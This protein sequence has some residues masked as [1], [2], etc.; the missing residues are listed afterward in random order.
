MHDHVQTGSNSSPRTRGRNGCLNC[1][2]RRKKCDEKKPTCGKCSA[3]GETCEVDDRLI[4]RSIGLGHCHPSQGESRTWGP[5]ENHEVQSPEKTRSP[6]ESADAVQIISID[7][8]QSTEG[9]QCKRRRIHNGKSRNAFNLTPGQPEDDLLNRYSLIDNPSHDIDS[10]TSVTSEVLSTIT[11]HNTKDSEQRYRRHNR[12]PA[13]DVVTQHGQNCASD[14]VSLI[15]SED[16]RGNMYARED[17]SYSNDQRQLSYP[18][19][20]A[21]TSSRVASSHSGMRRSPGSSNEGFSGDPTKPRNLSIP[22]ECRVPPAQRYNSCSSALDDSVSGIMNQSEYN[23]FDYSHATYQDLH[24]TLYKHMV[25]TAQNNVFT[26]QASPAEEVP[27]ESS[28]TNGL[29][30][31]HRT[32]A[33]QSVDISRSVCGEMAADHL[34]L[35]SLK[36]SQHRQLELW[37]NYLDEVAVW[38]DMFDND[39]HFQFSIPLLAKSAD[40][41]QYAILA[42]SSRQLER[43][44][45]DESNTES[46]GLYQEAIKLIIKELYTLD[47]AVIASCVLLCVLEMMSS[48]PRAW[49]RHLDGCAKLL[50]AASVNGV[51]GGIGQ[52]VFWCFARMDVWGG[53]LEDTLTKIP[54]SRWYI[55]GDSMEDLMTHFKAD[56]GY[57]SYA[58]HAV[59]LCASVVNVISA[60]ANEGDSM[61][62]TYLARWKAL[63]DLLEDWYSNR[64]T[65]MQPL[66]E[67]PSSPEDFRDPF[68]IVL[69]SGAPAVNG[70]QLYHAATLLMLQH[71]PRAV[72]LAKSSKSILWHA[73]QICGIAASNSD[74]GASINSLQPLWIAGKIMSHETEHQAILGILKRIE[75]DTG[76]ATAWRADDLRDYWG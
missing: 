16:T 66:M 38:L 67:Y 68:P 75:T 11:C 30:I 47:T 53:F 65:S 33:A 64:P 70:N 52:S 42:L 21:Q 26:R 48:S 45:F 28:I 41:L 62:Q 71:K 29:S 4:F 51:G 35:N 14:E 46:L 57:H 6:C 40:H 8:N 19:N 54:T 13:H 72:Q 22:V 24:A 20:S 32:L 34:P 7:V 73:R 69:Y 27:V 18:S 63:F 2:R 60:Q 39:R 3:T 12:G 61:P 17:G 15:S 58:N 43:K 44:S 76:W 36:M 59:F 31:S 10:S 37:R 5:Y 23:D 49:C 9:S 55:P 1:R 56:S 50:E 25:E 74:H